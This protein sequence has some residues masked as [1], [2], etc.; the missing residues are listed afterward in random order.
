MDDTALLRGSSWASQRDAE[1]G[2]EAL[3]LRDAEA[4]EEAAAAALDS[5][6][7]SASAWKGQC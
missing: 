2:E 6:L 7:P 5:W 1:A 4:G 3:T